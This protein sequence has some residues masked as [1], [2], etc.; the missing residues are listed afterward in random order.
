MSKRLDESVSKGDGAWDFRCPVTDGSCGTNGVGFT[1]TGWPTKETALA[2][3]AQHFAEHKGE[4]VSQ[5]LEDF[6]AEHGLTVDADGVVRGS[7]L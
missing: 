1:S 7:D 4:G 5:S 2:R 3:G 6:R